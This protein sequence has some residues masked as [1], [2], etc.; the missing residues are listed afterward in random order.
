MLAMTNSLTPS[1]ENVTLN[2]AETSHND[3]VLFRVSS[4]FR[5][6]IL[7]DWNSLGSDA[8]DAAHAYLLNY[9]VN[10]T[11]YLCLNLEYIF[12]MWL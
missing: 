7:R 12:E 8:I 4:L 3:F 2:V 10:N 6:A 1:D 11:R 9:I 5:H